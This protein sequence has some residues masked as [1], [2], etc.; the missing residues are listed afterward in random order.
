MDIPLPPQ[1]LG[2]QT[3]AALAWDTNGVIGTNSTIVR[4]TTTATITAL[5]AWPD[6]VLYLNAGQ[7]V[8][9]VVHGS[10]SDGVERDITG[11][12]GTVY[13]TTDPS[14]AGMD[15][16]GV[17]T[18]KASG[19]CLVVVSNGVSE[20]IPL[21]VQPGTA[22][23]ITAQPQSQT[24]NAGN[25]A[26]FT[27]TASG[28]PPL[29]YHWRRN[30]ANLANTAHISGATTNSLSLGNVS[31]TDAGNYSVVVSDSL[32]AVTSSIAVLTVFVPDTTRPTT[33]ITAPISGQ[34]L[35]NSL[36]TVTGRAGDNVL[37]SNVWYQ[38]NNSRWHL[39]SSANLWT[40]W[41][42]EVTLTPGTNILQ[43]FAVDTSGNISTTSRVSFVYVL[44]AG[45]TL[46][47]NG[48]G[49]V[50]PNYNGT[51]LQIGK[52]YSMTATAERGSAF[53]NWTGSVTTNRATLQFT[54]ASNLTFTANF[55]DVAKP[56]VAIT[57]P[58]ANQRLSNAVFTVAGT[59][60]DNA[61]V[62]KVWCQFNGGAW[63]SA[64]GT[65]NWSLT[66]RAHPGTNTISAY[67]V[68]TAGNCSTTNT[69]KIVY[70]LSAP[71]K[72]QIVG[73]GTVT[74]DYDGELLQIGQKLTLTAKAASG[75]RFVGWTG[76]LAATNT[77]LTFIMAPNLT[78][79]ATFVDSTRPVNVI[80]YP[81][82]NAKVTNEVI[83][84]RGKA[85][86]N[87]G[88]ATVWYQFNSLGWN[89]ALTTDHWTN[90]V[91]GPLILLPRTN[92][93]QAVAEDAAQN[94]SLTNTVKFLHP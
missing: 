72:V 32:G 30:G 18:A 6:S 91:T 63:T 82:V 16:N 19:Y 47:I 37:V 36:F 40:N 66:V 39:A 46:N 43:A 34:R 60:S 13:A 35:S 12:C 33:T 49:T 1:A 64:N 15:T 56:A 10:F 88:V 78:L 2:P 28:A 80:S 71:S 26:L 53:A 68:D 8:P 17:L 54:M 75:F 21:L 81:A 57:S 55:V 22:P 92:V 70:V 7:T 4:V 86:D 42:A 74:P 25:S 62:Y 61:S 67:A 50:S 93:I 9:F 45:L 84:A 90:W 58:K 77:A 5:K 31:T 69:V 65:T 52:S 27:V 20:R 59:A 23:V 94:M 89:R 11:Q 29:S 38:L 24:V 76:T 87:V 79:T 51:L 41:T 85:T 73:Q 14:V 44:S 83:T 48:S 3:I